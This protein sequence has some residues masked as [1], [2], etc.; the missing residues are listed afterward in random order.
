VALEDHQL[1]AKHHDLD[2]GFQIV[3]R[4]GEESD[5]T[6][7]QEIPESQEHGPNLHE[8]KGRS[9]EPAAQGYD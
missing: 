8:K 1:V 6:A 3:G 5:E 4:V 2:V 7:Q 9:Y